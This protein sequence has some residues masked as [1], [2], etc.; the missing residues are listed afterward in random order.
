MCAPRVYTLRN[1]KYEAYTPSH[2]TP[3][4]ARSRSPTY[5]LNIGVII[6]FWR[7]ELSTPG[8]NM[9]GVGERERAR[10]GVRCEGV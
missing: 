7:Q 6:N 1:T 9:L 8:A 3:R 5:V 4:R 10:R 2:R